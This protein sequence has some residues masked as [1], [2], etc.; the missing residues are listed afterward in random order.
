M[1]VLLLWSVPAYICLLPAA[2]VPACCLPFVSSF[3]CACW[4][5]CAIGAALTPHRWC[6]PA[7]DR[8][9]AAVAAAAPQSTSN[10]LNQLGQSLC[11]PALGRCAPRLWARRLQTYTTSPADLVTLDRYL[12]FM[13]QVRPS[14]ST[15][16]VE[17]LLLQLRLLPTGPVG[18]QLT[19]CRSHRPRLLPVQVSSTSLRSRTASFC[20]TCRMRQP[21]APQPTLWA[22]VPTRYIVRQFLF[23]MCPRGMCH[24][25]ALRLSFDVR[26]HVQGS[27]SALQHDLPVS[28]CRCK[29]PCANV[30][31]RAV[32]D[33]NLGGGVLLT[34]LS[35]ARFA[36]PHG[37]ELLPVRMLLDLT[38]FFRDS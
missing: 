30:I 2:C 16:C 28:V 18:S 1:S 4:H 3:C 10:Q 36:H 32:L 5:R 34:S 35:F 27:L 12:N 7:Y 21:R 20:R 8:V 31:F 23:R 15:V 25:L 17:L 29:S 9:V 19:S 26:S 24:L 14:I 38:L 13:C 11:D 22:P 33:S 37:M 6:V